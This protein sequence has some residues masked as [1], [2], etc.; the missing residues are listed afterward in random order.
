MTDTETPSIV[1]M[2]R[3]SK[4]SSNRTPEIDVRTSIRTGGTPIRMTRSAVWNNSVVAPAPAKPNFDNASTIRVAFRGEVAIQTSR[5]PV[6]R[7]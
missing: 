4:H 7:G 2:F 3:R 1:A 5:S 6:G